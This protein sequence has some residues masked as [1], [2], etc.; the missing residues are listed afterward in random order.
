MAVAPSVLDPVAVAPSVL[1]I[2]IERERERANLHSLDMLAEG[3]LGNRQERAERGR[4]QAQGAVE[5]ADRVSLSLPRSHEPSEPADGPDAQHGL[6]L[7]SADAGGQGQG[8]RPEAPKGIPSRRPVWGGA[9]AGRGMGVGARAE[10]RRG[11]QHLAVMVRLRS[12]KASP[13]ERERHLGAGGQEETRQPV[14]LAPLLLHLDGNHVGADVNARGLWPPC[15]R[16]CR[17]GRGCIIL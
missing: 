10:G 13:V 6:S 2:E 7:V 14:R 9:G 4:I 3:A 15:R 8:G 12:A 16:R 17:M 11:A 5:A 1:E